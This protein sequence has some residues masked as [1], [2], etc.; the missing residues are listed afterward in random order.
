VPDPSVTYAPHNSDNYCYRHPDRQSFVLC[1]RCG[2][3]I[4]GQCQ[5]LAAVGVHCPECVREARGSA[6]HVRPQSVT[7]M[8]TMVATGQPVVTYGIMALSVLG[9]LVHFVPGATNALFFAGPYGLHEPWRIVTGMFLHT[10]LLQV[11]FNM[12]SIFIFGRMLEMQVGRVRFGALYLLSGL[13]GEVAV[14]VLA[15]DSGL[16]GG[17]AAIFG[18]FA[19]FFVIQR[20]LGNQAVQ[21]L[22][23]LGLNI[24]IGLVVGAPWQAYLG[25][26]VIGG[27]AAYIMMQ[28]R[29]RS[30][31][32]R[33]KAL[34][35]AL[36]AVLV[37][38]ILVRGASLY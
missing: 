26:I 8:R 13:G 21:I 16:A 11:L 31:L 27:L 25:G 38:I 35:V 15:P 32:T 28:T 22:V 12:Y 23:I 37:L 19:A 9:Y 10:S 6:P 4:C 30:A 1:Q 24:V 34:L 7:R 33:Q 2:R 36:A 14:S 17:T 5:T 3:T 29:E 18:M 20:H